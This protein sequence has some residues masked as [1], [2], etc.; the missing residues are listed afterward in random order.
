MSETTGLDIGEFEAKYEDTS[1][2]EILHPTTFKPIGV[3][4]RLRSVDSDEWQRELMRIR[5]ENAR[6]ERRGNGVPP[7]KTRED[8][9]ALLAAVTVGWE[10]VTENG[11]PLACNKENARRLYS[12]PRLQFLREQVD[13]FV[14]ERKNFIRS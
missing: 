5:R 12:K 7:E 14:G 3:K 8:G 4:I 11:Q 6:Y 13:D 10:G 1:V 9:A 2:L